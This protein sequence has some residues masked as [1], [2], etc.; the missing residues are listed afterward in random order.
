MIA[1]GKEVNIDLIHVMFQNQL[2]LEQK[3]LTDKEFA[4]IFGRNLELLSSNLK[5]INFSRGLTE[6]AISS[7]KTKLRECLTEFI[8][9][10]RN[11][12]HIELLVRNSFY[13]R[14]Y[15]EAGIPTKHLPPKRFVGIGYRDKGT[16][17]DPAEDASP[18]W[19]EVSVPRF[20]T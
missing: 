6:G 8:Y 12:S 3:C 20:S 1:Y 19:Q 18:R 15:K 13:T 7:L 2:W 16:A 14:P 17:R 4:K 5:Q 10:M 9:P 11:M